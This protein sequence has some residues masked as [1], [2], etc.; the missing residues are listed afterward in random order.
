MLTTA[1]CQLASM[2]RPHLVHR[3]LSHCVRVVLAYNTAGGLVT[4][5]WHRVAVVTVGVNVLCGPRCVA[6]SW[7]GGA[8]TGRVAVLVDHRGSALA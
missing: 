3:V 1:G 8:D 7:A 5:R 2:L 4:C 6:W